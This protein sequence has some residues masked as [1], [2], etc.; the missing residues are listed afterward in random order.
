MNRPWLLPLMPL[1]RLAIEARAFALRAGLEKVERLERP[2][3]SI[4]NL[5]VGGAGKTPL[6]IALARALAAQGLAVDVLS[7]GYGRNSA[8]AEKVDP[9]GPAQRFG[10]EPLVIA[11]EAGVPVYVARR[12]F[13]AGQLAE[14]GA[15]PDVH[16]LDDG[17][18]HRQLARRVEIVLVER[19]D[20]RDRLLPAGNLREPLTA[21]RR[22]DVLA[23]P[24]TEPDFERDLRAW[25]WQGPIWRLRRTMEVPALAGPALAFCG[26]AR[27]GQFF[28]G[29]EQAGVK[30]AARRTFRDHYAYTEADL[31][32]LVEDGERAGASAF[33]TTAKDAARLGRLA[34]L[35]PAQRPLLTVGLRTE[36]EDEPA[37]LAWLLS[38]LSA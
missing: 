4:G 28:F 35:F 22:A 30:L 2:V 14:A 34:A 25:G 11:R 9:E 15:H 18:Q 21:L 33:L 6:A 7:R 37:A 12:R 27:P 1:Y 13:E 5:S 17:F 36:I 32:A 29:L 19:R 26:L 31:R 16:L 38:S 23:I 20:W 24:A 8:L 10:D 3:V